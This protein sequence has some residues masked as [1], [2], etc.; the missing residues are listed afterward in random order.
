LT[1]SSFDDICLTKNDPLGDQL[2]LQPNLQ[3]FGVQHEKEFSE[4]DLINPPGGHGD[5]LEDLIF[6]AKRQ[7]TVPL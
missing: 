1:Y 2:T 7:T 6:W 4:N 3:P 5:L